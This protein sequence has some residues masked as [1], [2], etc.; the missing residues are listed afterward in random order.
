MGGAAGKT[1]TPQEARVVQ[2]AIEKMVA[3]L[4]AK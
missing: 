1:L 3:E 2:M 4:P